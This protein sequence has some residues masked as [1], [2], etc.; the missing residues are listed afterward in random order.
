MHCSLVWI[1]I[2]MLSCLTARTVYAQPSTSFEDQM[3]FITATYP[4]PDWWLVDLPDLGEIEQT[5]EVNILLENFTDR[6]ER[7]LREYQHVSNLSQEIAGSVGGFQSCM[8]LDGYSVSFRSGELEEETDA[9]KDLVVL[10][11]I[12]YAYARYQNLYEP[13]GY[14]EAEDEVPGY[15]S[16][17]AVDLPDPLLAALLYHTLGHRYFATSDAGTSLSPEVI[18]WRLCDL[19]YQIIDAASKGAYS[20]MINSLI[21][22][23]HGDYQ[24]SILQLG[25]GEIDAAAKL[26]GQPLNIAAVLEMSSM[27]ILHIGIQ[28]TDPTASDVA[29]RDH[30][31][32]WMESFYQ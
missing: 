16:V 9:G 12:P 22:N 23:H 6:A 3:S 27:L 20:R 7:L 31:L 18:E 17:I 5:S 1:S 2:V 15:V 19:E 4:E 28:A 8:M 10:G 26:L 24:Q 11:I 32:T 29:A 30:F 25:P 14:V 21:V 13:V